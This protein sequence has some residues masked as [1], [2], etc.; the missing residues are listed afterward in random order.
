MFVVPQ[1]TDQQFAT[2]NS[3]RVTRRGDSCFDE[4]LWI[5]RRRTVSERRER[6]LS[7]G[8]SSNHSPS[9][10]GTVTVYRFD[11]RIGTC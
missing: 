2:L 1:H 6:N 9:S 10:S 8:C 11:T 5:H 4:A 3:P 7:C